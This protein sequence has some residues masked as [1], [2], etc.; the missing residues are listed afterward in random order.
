[1]NR[2]FCDCKDCKRAKRR[3]LVLG[4]RRASF[5]INVGGTVQHYDG[6]VSDYVPYHRW[7]K[8]RRPVNVVCEE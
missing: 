4:T 8:G 1:M 2:C 7:Q 5:F 3:G 6:P